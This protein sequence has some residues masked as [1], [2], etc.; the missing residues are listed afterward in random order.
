MT[1][2]TLLISLLFLL[3]VFVTAQG[4]TASG[5]VPC[6]YSV[7]GEPVADAQQC[8]FIDLMNLIQSTL[9]FVIYQ[10]ATP[11]AVLMFAYAGA[12]LVWSGGDTGAEKSARAIFKNTLIG[13]A[14]MLSAF[15]IVKLVFSLLFPDNFS[16][17]G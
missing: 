16:L 2:R 11:I 17:L 12:K 6:G 3:P 15:L 1:K 13:Y 14:V 8:D 4:K 5:M 10:L 9:N 7:N